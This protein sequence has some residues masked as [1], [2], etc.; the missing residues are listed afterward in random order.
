MFSQTL[1]VKVFKGS[2]PCLSSQGLFSFLLKMG[3]HKSKQLTIIIILQFF[4]QDLRQGAE[5]YEGGSV[6][7]L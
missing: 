1:A 4:N 2:L 6:K 3:T 5:V 7:V